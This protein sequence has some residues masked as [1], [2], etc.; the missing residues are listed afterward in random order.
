MKRS[1]KAT[2]ASLAFA[3]LMGGVAQA[4][5]NPRVTMII[6]TSP[7]VN[8][9]DPLLKGA[10]DAAKQLNIDLDIQYANNDQATENN[11]IQTAI[12][13]KVD[14]IAAI[15]WDDNA[16]NKSVCDATA[17]GIPVVAFNIDHS[18]GAKAGNCRLA[19][20]GQDFPATGFVDFH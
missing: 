3:G 6:Y 9:F 7:G 15:I 16:F 1:L 10:N 18:Q 14:G 19:F 17:A 20:I 2:L 8:F 12:A 11:I 5:D 4:A 13:N